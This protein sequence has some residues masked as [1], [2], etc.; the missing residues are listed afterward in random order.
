ME[1][2][3]G[4]VAGGGD[5]EGEG[6]GEGEGGGIDDGEGA[7]E[8]EGEREGKGDTCILKKKKN[9]YIHTDRYL[10]V[11]NPLNLQFEIGNNNN[12]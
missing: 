2:K 8:R 3:A 9:Y 11:V 12:M 5:G 6:E 7:G 4:E 1:K 10:A